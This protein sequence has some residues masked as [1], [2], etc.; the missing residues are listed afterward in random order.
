MI[1]HSN[2]HR[3]LYFIYDG[4][5]PLCK[6]AALA[7]RI[8]EDYGKLSLLNAREEKD[9][10][11]IQQVNKRQL[12]L[13]EGM[14]IY[15]EPSFYHGKDALR[16]MAKYSDSK[17]FFNRTNKA[18][19][20][21]DSIAKILYPWMRGIR[22]RL[23]KHKNISRIDNLNFKNE[24][25][26]K[27]IF[28]VDWDK[29]PEVLRKHYLNR[30][31]TN[32]ITVV[33]GVLD[34]KCS[35]PIKMLSPIFWLLRGIPPHTENDVAVTVNFESDK[36]TRA[37]YFNRLFHFK[38]RKPYYFKSKMIQNKGNEVIEIMRFGLG[39]KM[40]YLWEDGKVKLKHRGYII[41][42]LGHYL[43]VPLTFLIGKGHAEEVAI[44]DST[45]EMF[46]NITH[47]WWGKI[48]EYKGHFTIKKTYD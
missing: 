47:P 23:V 27:N 10:P 25:I 8:K 16:F 11:L 44:D 9:H 32:D 6:N 30:P 22:N 45:F 33:N 4:D 29:L 35:G 20:W 14:I 15:D 37:F 24:P 28:G 46:V 38:N 7:L 31:Y 41:H 17:G 39:W 48:Y 18:L 3:T 34:L 13:D 5:C 36:N 1:N 40:N 21:S 2:E 12:D 19:F 42:F 43:S 26:F